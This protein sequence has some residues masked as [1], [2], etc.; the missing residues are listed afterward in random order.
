MTL[1]E[2]LRATKTAAA[3]HLPAEVAT[4]FAAQQSALAASTAPTVATGTTLA[5]TPLITASGNPTTV[6]R[7]LGGSPAVLVFY[8]GGWC[9]YCNLTLRSYQ[10]DLLPQ[11]EGLGVKLVAISPQR[12]DQTL[13]TQEKAE[14]AFAVVSDPKN[15]LAGS[16]GIVD[17][18]SDDV[19]SAQA[20]LGLD[21]GQ[22][23]DGGDVRLP[24]PAV[25][26]IDADLRVLWAEVHPD[27]TTRSEPA[28]IIDVVKSL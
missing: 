7:L 10:T 19:R 3:D 27:Y 17:D 23:N 2:Q 4:T 11:L 9:P 26:V 25:V 15:V 14:L 8:R 5:D 18:G 6:T 16:L 22:V 13:S 1:A 20:S 12:P 21:L 28:T 24:M